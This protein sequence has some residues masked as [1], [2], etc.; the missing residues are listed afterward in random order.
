MPR[1]IKSIV[2]R[3]SYSFPRKEY[4][5]IIYEEYAYYILSSNQVHSEFSKLAA[6]SVVK[7]LS[8]DRIKQVYIPIPKIQ[9]N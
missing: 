4:K 2:K 7:N 5:N 8:I 1:Q 9:L 3:L 6:G